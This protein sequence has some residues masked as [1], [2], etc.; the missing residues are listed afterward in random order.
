MFINDRFIDYVE[1]VRLLTEK[2]QFVKSRNVLVRSWMDL[3][4]TRYTLDSLRSHFWCRF[5]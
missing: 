3:E 5:L 2:V 1:K 4:E